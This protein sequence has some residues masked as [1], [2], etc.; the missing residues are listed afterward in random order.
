MKKINLLSGNG[1]GSK[2]KA[3]KPLTEGVQEARIVRILEMGI[4]PANQYFA[5]SK[6]Q[7]TMVFC[8][9]LADDKVEVDGEMKPAFTFI[10]VNVVG[11]EKAKLTKLAIAAGLDPSNL[12]FEDFLGKAVSLTI[13]NRESKGNIYSNAVAFGGLSPRVAATVPELVADSYFLDFDTP[14][15]EILKKIS[16][17]RIGKI[18]EALNFSGS[19]MEKALLKLELEGNDKK[20]TKE[21]TAESL[22]NDIL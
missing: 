14:D 4:Q 13:K 19:E 1:G 15:L 16:P 22:D 8:F 6:P 10:D 17:Y 11:G 18:K 9:E 3:N 12:V 5:D 7:H 20:L 2:K 21:V